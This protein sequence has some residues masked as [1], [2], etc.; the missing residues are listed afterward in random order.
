MTRPRRGGPLTEAD[1]AVLAGVFGFD[2][3]EE[4]RDFAERQQ[5]RAEIQQITACPDCGQPAY[6]HTHCPARAARL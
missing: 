6:I 4:M 2:N 3:K 1:Y 5:F